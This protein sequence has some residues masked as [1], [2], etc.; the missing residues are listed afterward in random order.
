MAELS[1][2]GNDNPATTPRALKQSNAPESGTVR[3][4]VGLTASKMR[5]RAS[6]SLIIANHFNQQSAIGNGQFFA[7]FSLCFLVRWL[8]GRKQRFAKA[9]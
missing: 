6:S 2:A 5:L 7:I 8:S 4:G 9:P 3:S 1:K